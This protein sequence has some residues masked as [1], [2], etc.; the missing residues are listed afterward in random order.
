MTEG[1]PAGYLQAWSRIWTWHFREQIQLAVRAGR[2][3]SGPQKCKFSAVTARS[4]CRSYNT[5]PYYYQMS[6]HFN[7]QR[8]SL[9]FGAIHKGYF[10]LVNLIPKKDTGNE[11]LRNPFFCHTVYLDKN[12]F[13]VDYIFYALFDEL[14]EEHIANPLPR[15]IQL[16]F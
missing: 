8:S 7:L 15:A 3:Y 10:E 14:E 5:R 9:V 13:K 12:S 16:R 11:A 4:R 2:E 6:C 1:K